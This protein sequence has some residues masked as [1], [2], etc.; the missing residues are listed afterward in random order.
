M[1]GVYSHELR[2]L[3]CQ[4]VLIG[5]LM[6]DAVSVFWIRARDQDIC[7]DLKFACG[8][9]DFHYAGIAVGI[10]RVMNVNYT[11][12]NILLERLKSSGRNTVPREYP[13]ILCLIE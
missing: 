5:E 2:L 1:L 12:K 3:P 13:Q 7:S 9:G 10:V 11:I 4:P 6:A 8:L